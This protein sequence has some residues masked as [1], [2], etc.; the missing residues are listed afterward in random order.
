MKALVTDVL[1][2]ACLKRGTGNFQS[3]LC[4]S[5]PATA[6]WYDLAGHFVDVPCVCGVCTSHAMVVENT[7]PWIKLSFGMG[8]M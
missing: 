7:V 6:G 8:L 5:S 3:N 4:T 1:E 2:L